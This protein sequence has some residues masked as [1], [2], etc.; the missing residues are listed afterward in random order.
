M[1]VLS[2]IW[3]APILRWALSEDMLVLTESILNLLLYDYRLKTQFFP[4]TD[5]RDGA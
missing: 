3:V 1:D 4:G 5:F 2:A